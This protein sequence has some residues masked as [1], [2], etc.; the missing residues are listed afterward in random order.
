MS[1]ALLVAWMW[2]HGQVSANVEIRC[3]GVAPHT[4]C[5]EFKAEDVPAV[6]A[7]TVYGQRSYCVVNVKRHTFVNCTQEDIYNYSQSH[8]DVPIPLKMLK[9]CDKGDPQKDV[10][11]D[12]YK[13]RKCWVSIGCIITNDKTGH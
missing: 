4:R 9:W 8:P 3:S 11:I 1:L 12:F 13:K 2:M 6:Q 7:Q 5:V 10:C